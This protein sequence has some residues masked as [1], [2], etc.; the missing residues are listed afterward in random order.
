MQRNPRDTI[1]R[2]CGGTCLEPPAC[3]K[4]SFVVGAA[5]VIVSIA[6]GDAQARGTLRLGFMPLDLE[7]SSDTPLFGGEIDRA[8][9]RYNEA[10][11]ATNRDPI[12]SSALGLETTLLV[13]SPG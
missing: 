13:I 5:L 3:M 10:A 7:A 11:A 1:P 12:S 8:V 4:R 2:G 6:Q 9:D